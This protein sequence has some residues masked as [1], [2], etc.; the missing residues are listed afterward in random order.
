MFK[1]YGYKYYSR[2]LKFTIFLIVKLDC[3]TGW[4]WALRNKMMPA[5]EMV[6][7]KNMLGENISKK[8]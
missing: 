1:N 3:L 7:E 4:F 6:V 5:K 8:E 2:L